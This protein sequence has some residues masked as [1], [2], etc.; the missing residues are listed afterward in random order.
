MEHISEAPLDQ[1]PEHLLRRFEGWRRQIESEYRRSEPFRALCDDWRVCAEAGERWR[2]S[3]A[4][5]AA[6]RRREYREWLA[7]LEQ[8]IEDWLQH[9]LPATPIRAGGE[10]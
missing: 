4:P 7:E 6:Q 10:S 2:S 5:I 9:D 8:E 1:P 3:Q